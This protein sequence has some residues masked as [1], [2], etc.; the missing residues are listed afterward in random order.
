MELLLYPVMLPELGVQVQVNSVPATLDVR[1]MLV[2][3]LLHCCLLGGILDR[4]GEG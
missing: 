1:V 3:V 4:S 2:A